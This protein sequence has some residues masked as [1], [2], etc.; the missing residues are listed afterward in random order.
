MVQ[1]IALEEKERQCA[2]HAS[3]LGCV[4]AESRSGEADTLSRI[5]RNFE[6][7][8]PRNVVT[9]SIDFCGIFLFKGVRVV[10]SY[11]WKGLTNIFIHKIPYCAM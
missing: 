9:I 8:R 7:L 6:F 5:P 1:T 3:L 10:R 4:V 2:R 11:L